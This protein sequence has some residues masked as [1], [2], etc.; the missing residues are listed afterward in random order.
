[1][2]RARRTAS[3]RRRIVSASLYCSLVDCLGRRDMPEKS[4]TAEGDLPQPDETRVRHVNLFRCR[5]L[6]SSLHGE[7]QERQQTAF[8]EHD[9]ARMDISSCVQVNHKCWSDYRCNPQ[10]RVADALVL[11][12]SA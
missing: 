8:R 4:K 5:H 10:K 9:R 11:W 3:S 12:P 7:N 6:G 2:L 1:M